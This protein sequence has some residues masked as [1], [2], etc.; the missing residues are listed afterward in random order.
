M[1]L[2]SFVTGKYPALPDIANI[3]FSHLRE[4]VSLHWYIC[5][6]KVDI[7]LTILTLFL[8]TARGRN[9]EFMPWEFVPK[10]NRLGKSFCSPLKSWLRNFPRRKITKQFRAKIVSVSQAVRIMKLQVSLLQ[11][12]SLFHLYEIISNFTPRLI[13]HLIPLDY[14]QNGEFSWST[15]CIFRGL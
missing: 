1:C 2:Y 7:F 4:E 10:R 13:N 11:Y 6:W 15:Y 12:L 8:R 3:D 5:D 14:R 9:L